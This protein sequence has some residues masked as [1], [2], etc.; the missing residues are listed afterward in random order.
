MMHFVRINGVTA[1]ARQTVVSE[2]SEAITAGGGWIVDHHLYSDL[3]LCIVFQAPIS[4]LREL[5]RGLCALPVRFSEDSTAAVAALIERADPN[6]GEVTGT[7]EAFTRGTG[8]LRRV[9]PEVP[10]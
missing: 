3:S 1:A 5:W 2:L 6:G 7:L 9:V 4:D 8:D 10:G